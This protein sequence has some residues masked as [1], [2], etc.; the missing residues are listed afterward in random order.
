MKILAAG[1]SFTYGENLN[2]RSK[3]FPYLLAKKFNAEIV[4]TGRSAYSNQSIMRE[5]IDNCDDTINLVIVGFTSPGRIEY[6]DR[7]DVFNVWPGCI[8]K[9][10]RQEVS[11]RKEFI[12]Y[13]SKHHNDEWLFSN[14]YRTALALESFLLSH[15]KHFIFYCLETYHDHYFKNYP[16]ITKHYKSKFIS[17]Y[18]KL[19][20]NNKETIA[21][22]QQNNIL[23]CGHPNELG[24]EL[25]SERLYEHCRNICGL[26]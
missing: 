17:S 8:Y 15:G 6:C 3:A 21:A 16:D 14:F 23:P 13:V 20:F 12:D 18:S 10:N 1:D 4:N 5:V 19:I 24:H 25:I 9:I 26:S 11:H 22:W 7:F 2:D